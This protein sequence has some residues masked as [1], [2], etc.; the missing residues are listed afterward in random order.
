MD[1]SV[2]QPLFAWVADHP[3]WAG[4]I[5]F[6][7]AL[8]ESLAIVGL[9]MPGAVLLFGIGALIA[10]GS[11]EL[12]PT[13]AWAIAGAIVGDGVSFLIG[14]H[15]QDGLRALWPFSRY[16]R[17]LEQGEAFFRKHGGK[18]VLFGRFVGPVRPI[19][20]ATAGMM[21]MSPAF[22]FLIDVPSAFVWAPVYI[23]PGVAFGASLGL[24]S[25]V[26]ARLAMLLLVIVAVLWFIQWAVRKVFNYIQP[27]ANDMLNRT[28]RWSRAHARLGPLAAAIIEPDHPELRGLVYLG[29]ILLGASTAFFLLLQHVGD[30]PLSYLNTVVLHFFEG[31]RTPFAD[32][33][34]VAVSQLG[35]SRVNIPVFV[36]VLGWLAWR[37]RWLASGHWIGA[38]AF[39]AAVVWAMKL[40]MHVERPPTLY[41]ATADF[42]FPSGHVTMGIMLYGFLAVMIA[43]EHRGAGRWLPYAAAGTWVGMTALSRLYLGAHWLTDVLGGFMLGLAWIALLGIAYRRHR[44]PSIAT[45]K[46]TLVAS[47]V[48]LIAGGW[49]VS[50]HH[51]AELQHYA[52]LIETARME[53][54][55]W[56]ETGWQSL[57]AYRA[58]LRARRDQPLTVQYAG[59]PQALREHLAQHGWQ[60]PAPLSFVTALYWLSA[61]APVAQLPVLPQVHDG[62]HE[63][64]VLV[65]DSGSP[66]R[67]LV[68]RLWPAYVDL[69][70]PAGDTV[71]LWLG[72]VSFYERARPMRLFTTAHTGQDFVTPRDLLAGDV[73]GLIARVGSRPLSGA[74]HDRPPRWDGK[75]LLLRPPPAAPRQDVFLGPR[76]TAV[77]PA[78][79]E[80]DADH[81]GGTPLAYAGWGGGQP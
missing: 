45:G 30:Q 6:G 54:R 58:D 21:G 80:S 42:A 29:V 20:P 34:M 47:A 15:Y 70:T 12:L 38:V 14:Y 73:S 19:M 76:G 46:L 25:E 32:G 33:L 1:T 39:G 63:S 2:L 51:A 57:P 53:L 61:D 10:A 74:D 67:R 23:L 9:F 31:L 62:W 79:D 56:Q 27:R 13:L 18:G 65:R 4:L 59:P 49:H 68:L 35:S 48:F 44:P 28:L 11:M 71:P 40:I 3:T 72:S 41:A 26:A 64:L 17:L 16:P 81:G 36:A 69:A 78:D 5:V 77:A 37:R 22:F 7:I 24:A 60:Q 8:T 66:E 55:D 43:R 50:R 52:P 75:V